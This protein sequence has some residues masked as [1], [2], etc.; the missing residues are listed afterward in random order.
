MSKLVINK[1]KSNLNTIQDIMTNDI[2]YE[3]LSA[4]EL[5][6]RISFSH[7]KYLEI[8]NLR[9]HS[10]NIFEKNTAYKAEIKAFKSFAITY[11]IYK[12]RLMNNKAMSKRIND[13]VKNTVISERRSDYDLMINRINDIFDTWLTIANIPA[14]EYAER[15]GSNFTLRCGI[16]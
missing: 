9:M 11:A 13:L 14:S 5:G 1:I 3:T 8:V 2:N 7:D 10:C 15:L 6:N 4:Y 16:K 12:S